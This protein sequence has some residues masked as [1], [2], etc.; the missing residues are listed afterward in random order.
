MNFVPP[1]CERKELVGCFG[2][3]GPLRQ[4]FILYRAGERKEQSEISALVLRICGLN[5]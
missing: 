5:Y 1:A 3:N 4:Y 2:L